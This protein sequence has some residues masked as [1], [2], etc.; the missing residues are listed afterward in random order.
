MSLFPAHLQPK[1]DPAFQNA[2]YPNG[3][4]LHIIAREIAKTWPKVNYAA[5]PYLSAMRS[6]N[7][8]SDNYE[9]DSGYSVVAY[10]LSNATGWRGPEAKRIKAELNAMLKAHNKSRGR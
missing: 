7:S 2:D 3:R 9:Y 1:A 8:I 4:P 5:A 10:F 6:L